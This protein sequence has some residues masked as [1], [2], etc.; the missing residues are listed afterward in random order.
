M[1]MYSIYE[2]LVYIGLCIFQPFEVRYHLILNQSAHK[3]NINSG[4]CALFVL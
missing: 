2:S 1:F 3:P 4:L